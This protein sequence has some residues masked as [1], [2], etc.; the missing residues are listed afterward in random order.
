MNCKTCYY[1]LPDEVREKSMRG[2]CRN[3]RADKSANRT[4]FDYSCREYTAQ[5]N[6]HLTPETQA[7]SQAVINAETLEPSDSVPQS[8]QAQ[9]A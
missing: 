9:V 5:Q 7:T 8:A 6:A 1:W 4:V 2:Y 3:S